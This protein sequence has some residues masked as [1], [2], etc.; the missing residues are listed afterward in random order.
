MKSKHRIRIPM[1]SLGRNI[2]RLRRWWTWSRTRLSAEAHVS[3]SLIQQIEYDSGDPKLSQLRAL[4]KALKVREADLL[5][6]GAELISVSPLYR[7]R[8]RKK[9]FQGK[10]D[11]CWI[12]RGAKREI[13]GVYQMDGDRCYPHR[14]VYAMEKPLMVNWDID[15][16]CRNPL[17]VNPSH[18]EVVTRGTNLHLRDLRNKGD[19]RT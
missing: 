3:V 13:Y 12:W 6:P 1:T 17:C 10:S 5:R 7:E 2:W 18:L 19:A 9:F 11:E 15:H 14:L 16:T 4:A 8:I